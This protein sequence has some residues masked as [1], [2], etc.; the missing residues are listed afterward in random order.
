M[1]RTILR[2]LA[3]VCLLLGCAAGAQTTSQSAA[4]T[5]GQ[6]AAPLYGPWKFTTGDSPIDPKTGGPLWAEPGFDDSHWETVDL[7]PKK[8]AIDPAFGTSDYVPGWSALGHPGYWGYAW[9]RIRVQSVNIGAESLALVGP[10]NVDDAYQLFADGKLLGSFG[11]FRGKWP[12]IYIAHPVMF[13]LP[14]SLPSTG[15]ARVIAFRFWMAPSTTLQIVD[16]GGMHSAPV[17]GGASVVALYYQAKWVEI[18][19]GTLDMPVLALACGLLAI[20]AFSLILFDPSD[21]SY[22]WIGL[23]FLITG[24]QSVLTAISFWTELIPISAYY[25]ATDVANALV[26]ALWCIVWW[27]WFGRAGFRW[28]PSVLA[29]LTVALSVS[30]ILGAQ[31][32]FYGL[33]SHPAALRVYALSRVIQALL[34][35]LLLWIVVDGIRRKGLDG[36]LVLPVVLLRGIGW[37][38]VDLSVLHI[39]LIWFPFRIPIALGDIT[40][41]L[42]A[43]VIAL[44]LVRRLLYSLRRQR[45][46]ALDVKQAQEVQQVILPE[47][48]MALPGLV[49]ESEYR[50]AREV[51]GDFFQIVPHPADE[52]LLIVAGDV[53]GKGLKAGML[54]A[55]LVGAIRTAAEDERDPAAMLETLNRRLLGRG[56]AHATCLC[57]HIARDG[58]ATLA[59]AGHL[60]P[61]LNGLPMEIEGSLPLGVTEEL[62]CSVLRFRVSPSDWLLLLSDGVAEAM[63]E[64]GHLLGFDRV[65]ELVRAHPS[66][67]DIAEAAQ[68]FGQQDDISVI[69]ITRAPVAE[70]AMA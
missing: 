37:F 28:L 38:G 24:L 8:G 61:Y 19:R 15:G 17:M 41:L 27:V 66:A 16:A 11:N 9:Y 48:R 63:D 12:S 58:A 42:V 40:D 39:R 23:L 1:G 65:Q 36:W 44:L 21:R 60:P 46:M 30:S 25:V 68:A 13:H 32:V 14:D 54:V 50:P 5:F 7:K 67:A 51:G 6:A 56:D 3:G 62:D 47:Q 10:A 45:Q 53:A 64:R 18:I 34:F 20:T 57:L 4:I 31:V 52:S 22:F 29:G 49:I 35:G 26:V 43:V 69:S 33:I 59:N 55:L 70:P 2:L